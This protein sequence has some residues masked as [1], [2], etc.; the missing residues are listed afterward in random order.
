[1]TARRLRGRQVFCDH[2]FGQAG[3]TSAP[4]VHHVEF[5]SKLNRYLLRQG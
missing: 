3:A 5:E 2:P 4:V 1:M